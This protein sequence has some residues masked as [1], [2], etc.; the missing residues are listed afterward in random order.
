MLGFGAILSKDVAYQT[1]SYL[2]C[3]N[4]RSLASAKQ[5]NQVTYAI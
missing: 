3:G 2:W 5:D 4:E 1:V